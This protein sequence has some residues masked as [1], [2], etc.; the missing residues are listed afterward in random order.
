MLTVAHSVTGVCD[1]GIRCLDPE[2]IE[3]ISSWDGLVVGNSAAAEA[4]PGCSPHP[5][6]VPD[7]TDEYSTD[8]IF[9]DLCSWLITV[10]CCCLEG[11][12]TP[13]QHPCPI[14]FYAEAPNG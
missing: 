3:L 5:A 9:K 1:C 6:L 13:R 11:G 4:R 10:L 2:T 14:A 12:V 8:S 7:L